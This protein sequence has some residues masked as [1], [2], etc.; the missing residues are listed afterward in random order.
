MTAEGACSQQHTIHIRNPVVDLEYYSD[1]SFWK[2]S[3]GSIGMRIQFEV[4]LPSQGRADYYCLGA[5]AEG[6]RE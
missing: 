6:N 4:Q 1:N 2:Q 5:I 3:N